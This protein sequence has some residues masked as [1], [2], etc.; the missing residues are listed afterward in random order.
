MTDLEKESMLVDNYGLVIHVVKRY[1][2]PSSQS[3]FEDIIQEVSLHLWS[4][5][6]RWNPK[7][8]AFSTFAWRVCRNKVIDLI[9]CLSNRERFLTDSL[10]VRVEESNDGSIR[11]VERDVL[12][13]ADL[14]VF[15]NSL[16]EDD[17]LILSMKADGYTQTEIASAIGVSQGAICGRLL[18]FKNMYNGFC[19]KDAC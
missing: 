10:D 15:L 3:Q 16:N 5:I 8:S 6:D 19:L 12:F 2:P 17:S 14:S 1:V 11:P 4:V 18:R 9:T 7:V 13:T